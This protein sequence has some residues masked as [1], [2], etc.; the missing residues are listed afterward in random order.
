[1]KLQELTI[2]QQVNEA[3][4]EVERLKQEKELQRVAE[5]KKRVDDKLKYMK[6]AEAKMQ[7]VKD[8]HRQE[9]S[10][11]QIRHDQEI[12]KAVEEAL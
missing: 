3:N 5:D 9:I 11:I 10:N 2:L 4:N 8:K 7:K 1:M 6:Q 12:Q